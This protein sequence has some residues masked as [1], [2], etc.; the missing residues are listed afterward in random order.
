MRVVAVP[1][2]VAIGAIGALAADRVGL[3]AV[4]GFG[5]GALAAVLTVLA[6]PSLPTRRATVVLLGVGGFGALRHAAH[7]GSDRAVLLALW[8]IGTL[9]ALLLLDRAE[10][11]TAAPLH[12]GTPLA[13]R[14]RE[15]ARAA[16]V[17]AVVA[18]VSAVAL[19]PTITDRLGRRSWPGADPLFGDVLD[20]PTS[21]RSADELDMT[22]RPRLSDTVVFTVDAPRADFW[23]GE[24]FDVWDGRTWTRSDDGSRVLQRDADG[25]ALV[26]PA[27][28]EPVVAETDELRQTFHVEA[29]FS[30]VVF[31]APSA[32]VVETDKLLRGRPDG[33]VVVAGDATSGFGKGAVYTVV[34]RR[35]PATREALRRADRTPVPAGIAARYAQEPRYATARVL[36]LAREVTA[37]QVTTYDKI[38]ALEDWLGAHTEYSLDAP[39]SPA[40]VDVVD[41]FLFDSRVGW[42][43]QIAS[44]LVV[45][46]RAVGIPARL[47]TGFVPGERD[48]L[49]GRFVVRE[50]E[51]HAWA[52][53]WFPG[54]GWQGFDPTAAVPL[55]GEAPPGGSLLDTARRHGVVL[56]I[57][58]ALALLAAGFAPGLLAAVAARR[59]RRASWSA[60]TIDRLE[61]LGRRSGRPRGPAETPREYAHALAAHLSAPPVAAVGDAVDREAFSARGAPPEARSA[62]EAVL[63]S[64]EP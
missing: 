22:T 32:R 46:A 11:E 25:N 39:L 10:A 47:V 55:A 2:A 1:A 19:V 58:A 31:A 5:G 3:P 7:A 23:R 38:R 57:A 26:P 36:A 56:A 48:R 64:L 45:M 24:T 59:A 61:R 49:T 50:R 8:S 60:R 63:S 14:L 62:A 33:T 9:A 15:T 40:G 51:A 13:G 18:A 21:L 12:G 35:A 17:I 53:I 28:G 37:A 30:D 27:A 42:C 20:A 52:E 41:D 4:L 43:E 54:V 29:P 16:A 44:S 6:L 34:S